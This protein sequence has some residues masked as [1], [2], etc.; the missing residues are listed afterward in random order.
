MYP[1]YSG[2]KYAFFENGIDKA[3]EIIENYDDV[4]IIAIGPPTNLAVICDIC[5]KA[6]EIPVYAMFG[7]IYKGYFG[8]DHPDKEWNAFA[9]ILASQ[10]TLRSYHNLNIAPLDSCGMIRFSGDAYQKFMEMKSPIVDE[11]KKWLTLG[12]HDEKTF[13]SVLYDTQPVYMVLDNSLLNYET[14]LLSC[15]QDGNIAI[16]EDGNNVK[17]ALSWENLSAFLEK[18][19][20]VYLSVNHNHPSDMV[21]EDASL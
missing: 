18:L 14:L 17:C 9:D 16:T 4:V 13:S 7:S 21:E 20:S 8:A 15:D 12:Y 6:K 19:L 5:E 3:K 2:E 10:K 1:F 11:Y